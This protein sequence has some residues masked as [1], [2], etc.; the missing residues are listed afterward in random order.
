MLLLD[1]SASREYGIN[2]DSLLNSL[3]SYIGIFMCAVVPNVMHDILE[4]ALQYEVKLMIKSME[5]YF[6]L[7]LKILNWG[8]WKPKNAPQL[9]QQTP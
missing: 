1:D 2:R 3:H 9:L 8:T 4:G 6:I 5:K 7:G